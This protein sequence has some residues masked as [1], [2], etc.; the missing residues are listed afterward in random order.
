ML[1]AL[2]LLAA[3]F[4]TLYTVNVAGQSVVA[5]KT[6]S[7]GAHN[8]Y[9]MVPIALLAALLA[10]VAH[11]GQSRAA[12]V[13]LAALGVLSLLIAVIG[14]LPDTHAHGLTRQYVLASATAGPGLYL[15][16]LGAVLL[17]L[18]GGLGLAAGRGRGQ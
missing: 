9:A 7:A 4:T 17:L 13:A 8:A 1:G 12:L 15:E 6:E 16:T 14:D 3:E 18:A 11:R 2:L 10:V 5:I